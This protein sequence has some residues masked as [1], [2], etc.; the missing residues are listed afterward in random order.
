MNLE[1]KL[2]IPAL[3]NNFFALE[4]DISNLDRLERLSER[5]PVNILVTGNQ[6]CGKSSLV[7][8][9]AGFYKRPLAT[10]QVGLLI[11]SGQLFG[12]QGLRNGETYF[13]SFLFPK[14]IQNPGCVI[15]L[16]EINRSETPH[17][18]NELFSVLSEDRSIWID[19]LG[20]VEVAPAVIFF[21]TMNEGEEFSGTDRL[22][23]A[24]GD[25]FYRIHLEHLPSKVEKKVLMLKTGVDETQAARIIRV[26]TKLRGN[27]QMEMN[28][29][30]R[31]S[32]MIGELVAFGASLREALIYSLQISP[33]ALE[34]LLLSLHVET[35]QKEADPGH[36]G[37]YIPW[38]S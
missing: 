35:G 26:V 15:H 27:D 29:S 2:K 30:I 24:L 13:Q 14:A 22:D 20:L 11:E 32:L 8:Q 31:H 7:R 18:L 36:Y 37:P 17:A 21:A 4:E 25:R 38:K 23:A 34:S 28:V 3:D 6:G 9:F 12:Q 16:E 33:D 5:H 19:G 10:F 1:N